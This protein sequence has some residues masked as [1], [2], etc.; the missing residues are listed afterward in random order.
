[1]RETVIRTIE[2][3]KVIAIVRGV[4]GEECLNLAKALHQGGISLME[5][6]F[7]PIDAEKRKKTVATIELLSREMGEEMCF[8]AGTVTTVEMVEQAKAAGAQ[9]IVSPNTHADVIY[10][11]RSH[12]MVSIPGAYTPTEI[13]FAKD[14]GGDLIKVFPAGSLGASYFK[15]VHAPLEDCKLLAFGN[16][17]ENNIRDYLAAGAVGAGVAS[18]LFQKE[19]VKEGEWWKIT[20]AARR[21]MEKIG[22]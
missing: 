17:N 10:A 3:K 9:Y 18:C 19:W 21:V 12:D 4:F 11:T 6:T 14:C 16:V 1:M 7:D 8:G 15:S 20:D 22:L 5:V 13:R 2:E